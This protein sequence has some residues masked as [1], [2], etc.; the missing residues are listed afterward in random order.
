MQG[1]HQLGQGIDELK[2]QQQSVPGLPQTQVQDPV[3]SPYEGDLLAEAAHYADQC[4]K[5]ARRADIGHFDVIHAHDWLTFPA[6]LAVSRATGTPLVVHIHSTEFDRC[7]GHINRPIF[8]IERRGMHGAMRVICVSHLTQS[9]VQHRYGVDPKKIQV[10]YNGIDAGPGPT[11]K[12]SGIGPSEKI[13]LFLGR[14]TTQKG[15]AF[16]LQAARRVLE[17]YDQ[18]KFVVAGSGDQVQ[19]MMQAAA[20]YGIENKVVFTGFLRGRDVE[21]VFRM[22]DVY[23]MP[24]VSEPFGIAPL[25]AISHDVPVIISRTSGVA[26]V[27]THA[28]KVDFWDIDEIANKIIA[29]LRHPPLSRTLRR[30]ADMEIRQL[31]WDGAAAKCLKVYRQAVE[32]M[33]SRHGHM[34]QMT[35][36]PD[37]SKTSPGPR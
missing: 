31:N 34:V 29:V 17:K 18:V 5:I 25:E 19:E 23:V 37:G 7:P 22:A 13:V 30:H 12:P 36:A 11:A 21:Q 8:D 15:P 10:I 32:S 6:G 26:E 27:L 1:L 35:S 16:F 14:I 24:S 4:V 20:E 28:L 33:E 9:V 2:T 3:T